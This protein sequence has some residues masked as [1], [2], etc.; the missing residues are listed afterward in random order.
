MD[1]EIIESIYKLYYPND[2]ECV[3]TSHTAS[4]ICK[5]ILDQQ[6]KHLTEQ[7]AE[8]EKEL[9][10]VKDNAKELLIIAKHYIKNHDYCVIA[11]A[12]KLLTQPINNQ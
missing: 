4:K 12:D 10:E 2:S 8:K 7:L 3:F 11:K 6:T 5:D 1:K 9:S